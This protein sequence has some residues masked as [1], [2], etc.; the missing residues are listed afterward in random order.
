[1]ARSILLTKTTAAQN[2]D[3]LSYARVRGL[4]Y[5]AVVFMA[6]IIVSCRIVIAWSQKYLD[7]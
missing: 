4:Y 1:M 3:V 7:T 5:L 6:T 2:E